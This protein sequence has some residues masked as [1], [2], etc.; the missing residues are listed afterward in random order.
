MMSKKFHLRIEEPVV[1]AHGE[2]G[3]NA[4][5]H[6]QFP[7]L[8]YTTEGI[9]CSWDY[10][11]DTIDYDGISYKRYSKDNGK[12]WDSEKGSCRTQY[13]VMK[14][15]KQFKGFLAKGA[16]KVDYLK[17]YTPVYISPAKYSKGTY[18]FA[19][20]IIED[21]DKKVF[22]I[23]VDENGNENVFEC[24]VNWPYQVLGELFG[25]VYPIT[26]LFALCNKCGL[27]Q[28][29]GDMYFVLYA[30]GFD[31]E[32]NSR[33]GAMRKYMD[34][35]GIYV[36]KSTDCA[37]TWNYLSQ[38]H[39]GEDEWVDDP[40]FEGFDEPMMERMS[41]GSVVMLIRTGAGLPSYI[42]RST[43]NCKTWSKP[44]KFDDIGVF[45]Q[46]CRLDCGVVLSSYGRPGLRVRATSDPTGLEWEEPISIPFSNPN[47]Y[48]M[49]CSYTSILPLSDREA[50]MS[51]SDFYY[52]NPKG[53]PVKTILVRKITVVFEE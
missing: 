17:K 11:N 1:V 12:T 10:S 32:A 28:I 7:H 9:V 36:F 40:E 5:G 44:K 51:Y 47:E 50:L 6:T 48:L 25:L 31:A 30:P 20:D 27:L 33:E 45:P 38:I 35:S 8:E 46:I 41:D 15:G 19:E 39:V 49:S 16:H 42:V 26:M 14:N 23:E 13:Q 53:I 4:W 2:V 29:D 52:P 22:A 24:K 3:D 37:R 18:F 34:K 21:A 43:D